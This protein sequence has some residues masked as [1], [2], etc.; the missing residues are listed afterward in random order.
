MYGL[1]YQT[2]AG[3]AATVE[4]RRWRLAPDRMAVFGYAHVPWMKKHQALLPEAALPGPRERWAQAGAPKRVLHRARLAGDRPRP[5]RAARRRACRAR[6]EHGSLRR[7]FQGYTTDTA[8]VLLG[9]GASSIGSLPQGYVQNAA[10][11]PE[12]RERVRAGEL[13]T[14]AASR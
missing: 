11:V 9:I 1:P 14:A 5:L 4:P 13:A 8:P 3:M 6:S 10:A 7:N 12:W 2:A